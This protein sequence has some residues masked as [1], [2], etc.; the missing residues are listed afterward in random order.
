L[1]VAWKSIGIKY[2]P[3]PVVGLDVVGEGL[4]LDV[5][6]VV[7]TVVV[8]VGCCLE[9]PIQ[10]EHYAACLSLFCLRDSL[11]LFCTIVGLDVVG[12]GLGLDVRGVVVTVVVVV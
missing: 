12:E 4:G 6:G 2:L 7:V 5:R 11:R 3:V 9:I 1:V 8:V 10:C